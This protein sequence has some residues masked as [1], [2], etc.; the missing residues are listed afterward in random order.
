MARLFVDDMRAVSLRVSKVRERLGLIRPSVGGSR[1]AVPAELLGRGS[2]RCVIAASER[3]YGNNHRD[4]L[5]KTSG[6]GIW[7][8]YAEEWEIENARECVLKSV[9]MHLYEVTGP[10]AR[11]EICAL[12]CEPS[13]EGDNMASSC[14]RCSHLH[15]TI[16][17]NRLSHAHFPLNLTDLHEGV[18]S[19]DA[20][21]D[22]FAKALQV[23]DHEVIPRLVRAKSI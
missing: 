16:D 15:V 12:H 13:V 9:A 4:W 14:K 11:E 19:L 17:G 22:Q 8:Q 23:F 21:D 1:R 5:F 10:N 2:S 7:A 20:L 18:I 6:D 3:K